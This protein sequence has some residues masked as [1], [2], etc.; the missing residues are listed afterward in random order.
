MQLHPRAVAAGVR[1]FAHEV[2]DS[3]STE[4]LRLARAGERGP[5]WV[6]ARSQTA[7]R[8]R[9]GRVWVSQSGNLYASLL[10]EAPSPSL[11]AAQ[12]SFVAA[13]AVH[14][15]MCDLTGMDARLKLKWPNDLLC[16]GAKVGGILI[17]GEGPLVVIGIGINCAHHPDATGYPSTSLSACGAAVSPDKIFEQ[18][19]AR[20][21]ERMSHWNRGA[22]FAGTRIDWLA[23]AFGLGEALSV[24]AGDRK[25]T[26]VFENLDETGRLVLRQADGQREPIT[27]GEVF[28]L[29]PSATDIPANA[30]SASNTSRSPNA[31]ANQGA[32]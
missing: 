10:L 12:L 29:N 2:L 32:S 24:A 20:M 28:L 14:D 3:T 26:G 7:G 11:C 23:R 31:P 9:R 21:Q 13:L 18:L 27:A 4:A 1:L 6:T 30:Q 16:E 17:E 19:S 8:G 5:F 22:G 25:L 15:T